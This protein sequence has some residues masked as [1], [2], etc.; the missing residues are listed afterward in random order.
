MDSHQERDKKYLEFVNVFRKDLDNTNV[1]INIRSY[2]GEEFITQNSDKLALS[3]RECLE[4]TA[5]L[6]YTS[7]AY[8]SEIIQTLWYI[9]WLIG[10]IV[11]VLGYIAYKLS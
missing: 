3:S 9:R 1:N 6:L 2:E 8:Q 5:Y 4:R 11:A 10:I 7:T